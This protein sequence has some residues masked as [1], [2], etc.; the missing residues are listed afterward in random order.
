MVTRFEQDERQV[1]VRLTSQGRKLRERALD[2]RS[3]LVTAMALLTFSIFVK[4]W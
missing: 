3:E 1:R 2:Y 4:T